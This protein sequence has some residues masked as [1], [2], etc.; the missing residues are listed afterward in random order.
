MK[1]VVVALAVSMFF[2][3]SAMAAIVGSKH[4]LSTG[5]GGTIKANAGNVSESCSFC[6]TP[7]GANAAGPLW[8]QSASTVAAVTAIYNS[9]LG[10][11]VQQ[12]AA[13]ISIAN[14]NAS[15][16]FMCL[17]CHD[18]AALDNLTNPPNEVAT[19]TLTQS[20]ITNAQKIFDGDFSNDHPVGFTWGASFLTDDTELV[21]PSNGA[22]HNS[23]GVK[24]NSD[25]LFGNGADQF[26]CSTCHD[27]HSSTLNFL[28]MDN[29]NSAFCLACH[30]GK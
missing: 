26:W 9:P 5:G 4:D 16:V 27:V 7:H 6:H 10:N 28:R 8:N 30:T 19:V 17:S 20:S 14:V 12:S 13:T 1:K 2:T 18:G 23:I 22:F 25:F 3:T 15:D 11:G 21:D 24:A 29:K